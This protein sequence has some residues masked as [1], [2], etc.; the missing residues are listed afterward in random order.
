MSIGRFFYWL[1]NLFNK[2]ISVDAL[3]VYDDKQVIKNIIPEENSK[4]NKFI[5]SVFE[6]SF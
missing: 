3:Q 6:Y 2:K 4:F 1:R 5:V